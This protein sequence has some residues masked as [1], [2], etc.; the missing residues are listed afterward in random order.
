[1]ELIFISAFPAII[2][3]ALM[4][5]P[6]KYMGLSS[7]TTTLAPPPVILS[8]SFIAI[9]LSLRRPAAG[10]AADRHSR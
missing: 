7:S 2:A 4:T 6:G 5:S 9:V 1:M 3:R 10:L 8:H